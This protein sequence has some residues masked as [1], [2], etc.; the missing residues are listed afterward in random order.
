MRGNQS[1]GSEVKPLASH[2]LFGFLT[3]WLVTVDEEI[4]ARD[5]ALD[6]HRVA[7]ALPS[8]GIRSFPAGA[9]LLGEHNAATI[10]TQPGHCLGDQFL[11]SH[12][13]RFPR[14][15]TEEK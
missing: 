14:R 7:G 5:L 1:R 9:A 8:N 3:K 2:A 12:T 15:V 4:W 6:D 11:V 10:S 13:I